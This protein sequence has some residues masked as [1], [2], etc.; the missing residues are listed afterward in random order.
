M[1]D[2]NAVECLEENKSLLSEYGKQAHSLAVDNPDWGRIGKGLAG[3]SIASKLVQDEASLMNA[4]RCLTEVIYAM[5]Y[6]HG[7]RRAGMPNFVVA[8][9]MEGDGD[10]N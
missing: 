4:L 5:G 3:W 10:G 1:I 6:E 7:K 9:E 2:I 8:P